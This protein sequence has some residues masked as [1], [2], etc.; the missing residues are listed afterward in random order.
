MKKIPAILYYRI[1]K[2]AHLGEDPDGNPVAVYAEHRLR[3]SNDNVAMV[4]KDEF[5]KHHKPGAAVLARMMGLEAEH[6]TP[7]SKEEYDENT[8]D[9]EE[10]ELE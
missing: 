2:E 10:Y 4:E 6:V 9:G 3:D 8:E 1:E 5:L 7:V